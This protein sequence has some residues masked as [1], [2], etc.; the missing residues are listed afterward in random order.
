MAGLTRKRDLR[1]GRPLWLAGRQ[2]PTPHRPLT[3]SAKAEIVVVGAGVSGALVTDALLLAGHDV[4][5]LDRRGPVQGSTAASTALLQFEIDTPLI[6]LGRKIGRENA[7]RA[8]WRSTTG[9]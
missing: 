8:Y 3:R 5:V 4:T 2:P 6:Q 1:S 9:V 7:I